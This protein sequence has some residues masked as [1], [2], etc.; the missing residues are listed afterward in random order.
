MRRLIRQSSILLSVM[1]LVL[2]V[3]V[4]ANQKEVPAE[5]EKVV[6]TPTSQNLSLIHI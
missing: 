3:L 5:A 4:F 2:V 6:E 1:A